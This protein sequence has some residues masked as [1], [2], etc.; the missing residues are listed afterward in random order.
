[1]A[2][3]E[4]ILS[5]RTFIRNTGGLV[6][7]FG[8]ADIANL[9]QL[10]AQ[11]VAGGAKVVTGNP[12]PDAIGSWLHIDTDGV[13]R[14]FTGKMEIGMGVETALMQIV[15]EELDVAV[16][17]VKF[18]MGDTS[19]TPDQGGVGGSTSLSQGA[20]P[21]RNVAASARALLLDMA[22]QKLG[23]PSDQLE[24]ENGVVRVKGSPEKR[25]SY[26]ELTKDASLQSSLVV[27]GAGSALNVKGAAKPKDV[28]SYKIVGKSVP[29][30]DLPLK[31]TGKWQYVTDV[32]VPGMLHGRVIRPSSVGASLV[33]MDDAPAKGIR[34]YVQ[35]VVIGNFVG[36]VAENEWAAVKASRAVKVTWSAPTQSF[37]EQ[38]KLYD[39][40][41]AAKPKASMDFVKTGD[42]DAGMATA[43]KKVEATYEFPFQSHGTMGP[44]CGVADVQPDGV[45]TVWSGTQKPHAMQIGIADLLKVPR[46]K[47]R[48]IWTE[49]SGSYGRAGFEDA[50]GDAVLLSKAV[51]K[52]VRVQWMRSDM[53]TWG[54]KG[55]ALTVD[56]TAGLDAQGKVT[57]LRFTSRA[58]SGAETNYLPIAAGNFLGT[59][60]AGIPNKNIRDEFVSW[61]HETVAYP[62]PNIVANGH[63]IDSLYP[64]G[65]PLRT[66]HLRDPEGPAATFAAESFIDEL[67]AAAGVDPVEFRL[68]NLD[69]ARTKAVIKIAAEKFG[70]DKRT[71]PMKK[72]A[73]GDMVKGRGIAIGDRGGTRVA[74]IAEVE[75]NR[76]TGV[77]RVTRLVCAHDCG[78]I[79]NPASLQG[80]IEANLI[81]STSRSL[82]EEVMFDRNN[83]TSKDWISYPI[84]RAA[85]LPDKVE[86]VL[87]NHPEFPSTGAGEPSSRP[88]TA[89]INNAIFDATGVRLRQGPFT[90]ARIKA[91]LGAA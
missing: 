22:S 28:A 56:L 31:I 1:M 37:P 53:T 58:F 18:V 51:G 30:I 83:V 32:R 82:F 12:V 3:I 77:A 59:Q 57:A 54:S 68:A 35:T 43:V 44:G 71:S 49:D 60:L 10:M 69:D 45:T 62:F 55:P 7:G 4:K 23:V 40:M 80:T 66:T 26:G 67:A 36:V 86:V 6:I 79:V 50:A 84:L 14:I 21:L 70:W 20:G 46:D 73:A 52:P 81:Q 5:R 76:R 91:A 19:R 24:V 89:A 39:Y 88:T 16:N 47:V 87:V 17:Q 61:G 74:T 65:S 29:R 34:G 72:A 63:V 48:I 13:I 64:Q 8:I 33:A 41:R 38:A 25:V 85:N 42:F 11:A 15:A 78:L 27:S 2:R 90:P 9:P 75:V